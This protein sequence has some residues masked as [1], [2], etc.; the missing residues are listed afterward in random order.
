[1]KIAGLLVLSLIMAG[2]VLAISICE[3]QT[4]EPSTGFSPYDGNTVTV[5]GVVTVPAGIFTASQTSVYIRGLGDDVC[6]VNIFAY[7]QVGNLGLGDT[8]TVTG[9]VEEYVST[10]GSGATTEIMFDE[11]GLTNIRRADVPYVEPVGMRTGEV[12]AEENEG[13]LVR[14]TGTVVGKTPPDEI[15]LDDGSG[16][17]AIYD[18]GEVFGGDSTWQSLKWGDEVIISGVVTQYDASIPY[19]SDYQIWPRGAGPPFGDLT[20][21]QCIP[22]TV[23]SRAVLEIVDTD[24]QEIGIFCPECPGSDGL[25]RIRYNGPHQ[26]RLRVRVFDCYGREV[27]TL[28]DS[29][30]QCGAIVFEWDGRNEL[31][32]RLPVGLYHVVVTAIDPASGG[33]SQASAPIV[34]GRRLK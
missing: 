31:F 8:V 14:V 29:Y 32:E 19:L 18:F 28:D 12:G 5:T 26:S 4:Y 23:I 20:I 13:R 15:T 10:S 33:R 30:I 27:A 21:P 2:Q 22:D 3:V 6:G 16:R 11:T 34:I 24:D 9:Q 1:M 25:V 7:G 17:I